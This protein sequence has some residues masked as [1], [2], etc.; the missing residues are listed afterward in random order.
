MRTSDNFMWSWFR[1]GTAC[2]LQGRTCMGN[3]CPATTAVAATALDQ[4]D[5]LILYRGG[6]A[7]TSIDNNV[8]RMRG[9]QSDS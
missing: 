5:F 7:A 1:Q 2:E 8:L 9:E 6:K 3:N 4:P